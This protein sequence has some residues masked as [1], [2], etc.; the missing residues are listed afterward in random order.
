M[1]YE[2]GQDVRLGDVVTITLADGDHKAKIVILGDSG[3]Y[4]GIDVETAKWV[5]ESGHVG[6]DQVMAE[7][8]EEN[9]LSHDD[10]AYAPVANTISTCLC[11]VVL[12]RRETDSTKSE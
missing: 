10:P 8:V 2:D 11:D 4:G 5:L 6:Q 12:I 1:K 7:W 3:E 9:P